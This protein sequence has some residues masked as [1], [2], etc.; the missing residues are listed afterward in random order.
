MNT[1]KCLT[2]DKKRR[3]PNWLLIG[4]VLWIVCAATAC[5]NNVFLAPSQL[6]FLIGGGLGR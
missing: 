1:K 2:S 6:H 5:A 4:G 3:A